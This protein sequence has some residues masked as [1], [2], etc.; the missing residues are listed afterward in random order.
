MTFATPAT[1]ALRR[2]EAQKARI[3]EKRATLRRLCG[4]LPAVH[5]TW[6]ARQTADFKAA[7]A[8]GMTIAGL[9]RVTEARL[10]EAIRHLET[11]YY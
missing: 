5:Q 4:R 6:G 2:E 1:M 3:E 11:F 8:N 10:D 9:P 7:A